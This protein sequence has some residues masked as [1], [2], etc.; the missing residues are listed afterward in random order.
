MIKLLRII[1]IS[2]GILTVSTF[3]SAG[4]VYYLASNSLPQYQQQLK[5]R[6]ISERLSITRD[7]YAIPYIEAQNDQDSFFA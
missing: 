7:S 1:F 6:G 5:T 2:S 3:L 4:A